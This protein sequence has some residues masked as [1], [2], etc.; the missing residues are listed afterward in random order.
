MTA[1]TLGCDQAR[2]L[3]YDPDGLLLQ[4]SWAALD[5][6]HSAYRIIFSLMYLGPGAVAVEFGLTG[7]RTAHGGDLGQVQ[8]LGMH[9]RR[10]PSVCM[11]SAD[12][13]DGV[14]DLCYRVRSS[15][16][17]AG[18]PGSEVT[19]TVTGTTPLVAIDTRTAAMNE[20]LSRPSALFDGSQDRG[21]VLLAVCRDRDRVD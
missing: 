2:I 13:R 10:P 7:G 6:A 18:D 5:Q 16:E 19:V 4:A 12:V 15:R 20:E 1:T 14:V 11:T 8:L 17:H 21:A 9:A 3:H